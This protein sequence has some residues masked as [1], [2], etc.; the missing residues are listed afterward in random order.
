MKKLEKIGK[1]KRGKKKRK[2]TPHSYP[3][4][5]ELRYKDFL[6][7]HPC[8]VSSLPIRPLL[9]H[10]FEQ[11]IALTDSR[12]YVPIDFARS[13]ELNASKSLCS[14]QFYIHWGTSS[15]LLSSSRR[16]WHCLFV[17][18]TFVSDCQFDALFSPSG[19]R[20][21]PTECIQMLP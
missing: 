20:T 10:C 8:V 15:D 17:L 9:S 19:D 5:R 1:K 3:Q 18:V 11:N 4:L 6:D 14:F 2:G 7:P 12:V 21:P 16:R 13:W